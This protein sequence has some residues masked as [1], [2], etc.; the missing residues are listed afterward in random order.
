MVN[1]MI[2]KK[3]EK[4]TESKILEAARRVFILKGLD[5]ARMQEIA[6][7]A[8]I[9]KALLHY[10]FRSKDK[11]FMKIFIVEFGNFFPRLIPVMLSKDMDIDRKI[12]HFVDGY[13]EL[14]LKN[15]F[16]PAFVIR[17]INRNPNL[18]KEFV[19]ESGVDIK[20][21][22]S[23]LTTLSDELGLAQRE[24][25]HLLVTL[26]SSCI[27]PF[28]GKPIIEGVL[29]DGNEKEYRKFLEERKIYVA[30]FA[31]NYIKQ[32]TKNK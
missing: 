23:I 18:F 31:I 20:M 21:L 27:F 28:A 14:F 17:E 22:N 12:R 19:K 3:Y 7:E 16:L 6:D 13:I 4:D 26:V 25:M 30:E 11:L 15:P 32:N 5:G 9:N 10:Y 29:F 1:Y 24:I 8:G 2:A